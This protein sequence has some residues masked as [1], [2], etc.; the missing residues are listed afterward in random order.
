MSL[1]MTTTS[2][3]LLEGS[4][5]TVVPEG[6]ELVAPD[7]RRI[8]ERDAIYLPP[9]EPSKIL[10]VHLNHVTKDLDCI[11]ELHS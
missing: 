10:C 3:I 1:P 7:G 4:V 8:A 2:R 5:T 6:D 11:G 9:S